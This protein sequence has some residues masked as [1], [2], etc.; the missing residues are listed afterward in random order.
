LW[1]SVAN[2]LA[3]CAHFAYR[4]KYGITNQSQH[5]Q[6]DEILDED[7]EMIDVVLNEEKT[8]EIAKQLLLPK[9]LRCAIHILIFT[10][11]HRFCENIEKRQKLQPSSVGTP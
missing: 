11:G 10:C 2:L 9:H 7:D 5:A 3:N 1:K 6:T 8:E 4:G